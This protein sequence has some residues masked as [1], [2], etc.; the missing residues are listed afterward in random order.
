[1][2]FRWAS[3]ATACCSGWGKC[4][5]M[6]R[7]R[8][9][10]GSCNFFDLRNPNLLKATFSIHHIPPP[11][12]QVYEPRKYMTDIKMVAASYSMGKKLWH[13]IHV[14]SAY[15]NQRF[16][17]QVVQTLQKQGSTKSLSVPPPTTPLLIPSYAPAQGPNRNPYGGPG[18]EIAYLRPAMAMVY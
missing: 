12:L 18:H 6:E 17:T 3:M 9:P 2:I 14:P 4:N 11:H 15:L 1:V 13:F 7:G 8:W 16:P 5:Q 10:P